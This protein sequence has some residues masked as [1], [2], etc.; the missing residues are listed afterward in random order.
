MTNPRAESAVAYPGPEP[1]LSLRENRR[2]PRATLRA[3]VDL[4]D[5]LS[6]ISGIAENIS[7]GGVFVA[8]Y[9]RYRPGDP[10]RLR[11]Q[12][13]G[14]EPLEIRCRVAWVRTESGTIGTKPTGVGLQFLHVDEAARRRIR[15]IVQSGGKDTLALFNEAPE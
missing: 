11:I 1:G 5:D 8:T 7:E 3:I 6:S 10:L 15:T 14:E 13:D 2:Y 9:R 12:L 4:E